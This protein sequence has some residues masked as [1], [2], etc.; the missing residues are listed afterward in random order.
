MKI[1]KARKADLK[2][3]SE[4][5]RIESAKKPY[6]QKWNKKTA[7]KKITESFKKY[8]MHIALID[9]EIVGFVTSYAEKDNKEKAYVDEL[10]LKSNYQR[11]GIGKALMKFI[12]KMY[13]KKKVKVI[14]L[15]SNRKSGAFKFY[16]KLRYGESKGTVFMDKRLK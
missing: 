12:E 10:W 5:F 8:N 3:V 7:L 9:R 15:V 1:Q 13:K 14:Q 11:K 4:I 6:L 2:E 16:K